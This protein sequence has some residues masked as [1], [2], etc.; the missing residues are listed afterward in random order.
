MSQASATVGGATTLVATLTD[1]ATGLPMTG[2]AVTFKLGATQVGT[3]TTNASG[4]ATLLVDAA[5]YAPGNYSGEVQATFAGDIGA[6]DVRSSATLIVTPNYLMPLNQGVGITPLL[7]VGD[8]AAQTPQYRMVGIPDGLGA[9]DNGNGTFTVLM[10]QELTSSLGSQRAHGGTGAF[11]SKWVFDKTTLAPLSGA[12]LMQ[13]V[14]SGA[15]FTP[16]TG[17][18]LNFSRF[19]SADLPATSAFYNATTGNGTRT[20]ILLN[21]EETG[22]GRAMAHVVDGPE[23]GVSYTLPAFGGRAWENLLANPASGDTTLVMANEDGSI[24]T[25]RLISYVG[26]KQNTGNEIQRAG[27]TNGTAYQVQVAVGGVN[28]A[29]E[30]RVNGLGTTTPAYKGT[31]SLVAGTGTGFNR[32]EDGVWDPSNPRDYYFVTTDQAAIGNRNSRLWKLSFSD[33]S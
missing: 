13:T 26:T 14:K 22:G 29:A 8:S 27:L 2:K 28:V 30:S 4:V 15:D 10:N 33:L 6:I 32:A 31:F 19:C 1:G 20:R 7:S 3:A 9:Y 25:S 18:A 12:D 23:A 24:G 16:V 17:T 5:N 21:G 11:V